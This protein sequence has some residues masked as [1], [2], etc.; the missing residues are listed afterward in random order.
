VVAVIALIFC[1]HT[2]IHRWYYISPESWE[3]GDGIIT[4]Q[5]ETTCSSIKARVDGS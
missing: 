5:R 3:R 4:Q 1:Y 2:Q